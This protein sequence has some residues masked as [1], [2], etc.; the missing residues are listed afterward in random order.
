MPLA[1]AVWFPEIQMTLVRRATARLPRNSFVFRTA[2]K[3]TK[4]EIK[5]FLQAAYG[6]RVV[7][8]ATVIYGRER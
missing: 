1:R 7:R 4:P 5:Q 2:S 8:V 3:W 6:V